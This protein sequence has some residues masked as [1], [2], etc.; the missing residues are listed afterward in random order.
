MKKAA[1]IAGGLSV[2][3]SL[4]ACG[5]GSGS[6]NPSEASAKLVFAGYGGATGE[7]IT[8]A[9]F[10]PFTAESN[11]EIQTDP[12]N[13]V[14]KLQQMVSSNTVT[15]DL[16]ES[17]SDLDLV[18]GTLFE[19]IDCK[20][21]SCDDFTGGFK[22]YPQGVPWFV[23]SQV[24]AYNTEQV[25]SAP[26]GWGDFFDPSIPGNRAVN[27]GEG[28]RG[29]LE[30]ALLADGVAREQLYPLDLP[31]ALKA[32]DKI[33]SRI[34]YFD[35]GQQ[36]VDLLTSGE[37]SMGNCYNGSTQKAKDGG[38][39]VDYVW[40]QQVQSADYISIPKGS[41]NIEA[42]QKAVAY[43]TS[44][45]NNANLTPYVSYGPTNP[46]AE[47]DAAQKNLVPTEN[48]ETG[49]NAPIRPDQNWWKNNRE[50]VFPQIAEWKG[51]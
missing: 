21:V 45:E 51:N 17:G 24:I 8:K 5:S 36:C 47:V 37:A 13:D 42:A 46:K 12:T 32:F 22:A 44:A 3:L 34:I 2:M 31:R 50:S 38:E 30:G 39:P 19:D 49:A 33:K 48:E 10:D 40:S 11:I 41:K 14:A 1:L 20:I 9:W 7:G 18:D 4:A 35:S 26:K 28:F 27:G 15:W 23:Y 6:A 43:L 25:T 29:L 16:F